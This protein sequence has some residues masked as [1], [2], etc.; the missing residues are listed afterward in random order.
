MF[1]G[2]LLWSKVYLVKEYT[3][4]VLRVPVMTLKYV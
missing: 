2:F 3:L 1:L 4:D